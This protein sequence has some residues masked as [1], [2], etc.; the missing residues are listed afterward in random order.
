MDCIKIV[1]ELVA[2]I[3]LVFLSI[4][5]VRILKLKWVT[6]RSKNAETKTLSILCTEQC[7]VKKCDLIF[8]LNHSHSTFESYF[9]IKCEGYTEILVVNLPFIAHN[10]YKSDFETCSCEIRKNESFL[11]ITSKNKS[12]IEIPNFYMVFNENIESRNYY[13]Q[14]KIPVYYPVLGGNIYDTTKEIPHIYQGKIEKIIYPQIISL[15]ITFKE[16]D[17]SYE[18]EIK[19]SF[20]VPDIVRD[21]G[22]TWFIGNNKPHTNI[23]I[24]FVNKEKLINSEKTSFMYGILITLYFSL[25]TFFIT[26]LFS[27][28]WNL[29]KLRIE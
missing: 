6:K 2:I 16:T 22:M 27:T 18:P 29:L 15:E 19:E 11:T 4:K 10:N 28:I 17:I 20:P 13:K 9:S 24:S 1:I 25:L 21:N 23:N 3:V 14:I 26:D 12:D 8:L 5:S 7:V